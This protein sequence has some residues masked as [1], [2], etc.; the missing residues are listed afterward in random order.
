MDIVARA[1]ALILQPRQEWQVIA[2]EPADTRGLILGYAAPLSLI[3]AV[4]GLVGAVMLGSMMSNMVGVRIGFFSL[5]LHA[6]ASYVMGLGGIW[7]LGKVIQNL[8][9]RFGGAAEEVPAMKL[10]TYSATASWLAGVFMLIPVLGIFGL[11]GLYS[12]YL[13][14]TGAPAVTRVPADKAGV[15]TAAVILCAIV[16]YMLIGWIAAMLLLGL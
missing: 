5:L 15:F 7:V 8:A 14:Y 10:A 13:F 11:L 2:A 1:K 3:P 12:L 16:L 6:I 9:P 4:C